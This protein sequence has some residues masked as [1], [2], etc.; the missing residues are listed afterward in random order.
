MATFDKR[1]WP[2]GKTTWRVRVRRLNGPPLTKSF[3]RK[4]DGEE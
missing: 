2:S 1:V 3:A 4:A